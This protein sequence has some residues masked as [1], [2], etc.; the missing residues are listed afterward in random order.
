MNVNYYLFHPLYPHK[1]F[2][3][4]NYNIYLKILPIFYFLTRSLKGPLSNRLTWSSTC[5]LSAIGWLELVESLFLFIW[6]Q[7]KSITL[8]P[9]IE[10]WWPCSLNLSIFFQ[11]W[12]S[13][14][15][16]LSQFRLSKKGINISVINAIRVVS[17][18]ITDCWLGFLDTT[19]EIPI[20]PA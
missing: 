18:L 16:L 4:K 19:E 3:E 14:C 11:S 6:L 20:A 5:A 17:I 10:R 1:C 15:F 9:L 7:I 13:Y 2:Y 8:V 12:K